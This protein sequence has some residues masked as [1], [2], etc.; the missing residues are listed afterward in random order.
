MEKKLTIAAIL[1]AFAFV[2]SCSGTKKVTTVSKELYAEIAHMDSVLFN[3]FNGRDLET[4]KKIFSPDLEFYHDLGGL[5]N[6]DQNIANSK[7]LFDR[8]NGLHRTLVPGSLEVHPIKDYGAIQIGRHRFCHPE[9]GKE[10]CGTFKFVHIWQKKNN[11]WK[12]TRVISY[13]H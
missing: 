8:N 2:L 1:I 3:A 11:E 10:D 5:T 12:L 13:D 4:L 6:Y 9:N 7:I